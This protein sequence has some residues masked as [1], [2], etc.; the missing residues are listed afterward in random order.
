MISSREQKYEMTQFLIRDDWNERNN[1]SFLNR[2]ACREVR[3][4]IQLIFCTWLTLS[5][6]S[7][8]KS[9]VASFVIPLYLSSASRNRSMFCITCT[10]TLSM[11]HLL[12]LFCFIFLNHFCMPFDKFARRERGENKVLWL[13]DLQ[14]CGAFPNIHRGF[15]DH[16]KYS[17]SS[18]A[19]S[20][21]CMLC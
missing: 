15:L 17:V 16:A 21:I 9:I 14:R 11:M 13:V 3:N 2:Y 1:H 4:C 8:I 19:P 10:R 20:T 12:Y 18:Q 6:N 7:C 5:C